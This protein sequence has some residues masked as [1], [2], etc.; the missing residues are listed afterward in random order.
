MGYWLSPT[1]GYSEPDPLGPDSVSVPRR[2]DGTYSWNGSD[3]VATAT[4][5]AESALAA[6]NAA[7]AGK[8]TVISTTAIPSIA[9]PGTLFDIGPT[10]K[11][12]ILGIYAGLTAPSPYTPSGTANFNYPDSTG[13]MHS[14]TS[15]TFQQF[16]RGVQEFFYAWAQV[17]GGGS[18]PSSTIIIA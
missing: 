2:P 14:F 11:A 5:T 16:A 15:S 1:L 3:W 8:L 12:N 18:V 6:F 4:T 13:V 17:P 7:V 10:E 9:S